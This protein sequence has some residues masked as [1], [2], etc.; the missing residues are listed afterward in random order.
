MSAPCAPDVLVGDSGEFQFTGAIL[1]IPHP[2]ATRSIPCSASCS[3][4]LPVGDVAYRINL[5]SAVYAGRWPAASHRRRLPTCWA[6][7]AA[8]WGGRSPEPDTQGGPAPWRGRLGVGA[9]L[10][11]AVGGHGLGAGAGGPL[12]CAQR[13]A[14]LPLAVALLL[15]GGRTGRA[16]LSGRRVLARPRPPFPTTARR[17]RWCPATPLP[18]GPG[19]GRRGAANPGGPGWGAGAL[20]LG[21]FALGLTPYLFRLPLRPRLHLLLG[22]AADLGRRDLPGAGYAVPGADLRL[23]ADPRRPVGAADLRRRPGGGPVRQPGRAAGAVGLAAP[24]DG[25][26]PAARGRG[27]AR[28]AAPGQLRLRRQLWHHRPHLPDPHLSLPHPRPRLRDS[29]FWV[30]DFGLGRTVAA[31][32]QNPQSTI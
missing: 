25:S 32:F 29:G 13:A 3:S 21:A 22:Q 15:P 17:L 19:G 16:A 12:L 2:P 28:A 24:A 11:L 14:W 1:G 27:P 20:G 5:S 18:A 4:F 31:R 9:G 30:L 23:P 10:L 8:R 6:P 7:G 26:A